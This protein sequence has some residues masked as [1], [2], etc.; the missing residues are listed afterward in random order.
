M[1]HVDL[2]SIIGLLALM[3]FAAK[4][5]GW[6]CKHAGQPAELGE[7]VAGVVLGASAN[8]PTNAK[9]ARDREIV[10]HGW[11]RSR[12]ANNSPPTTPNANGANWKMTMYASG[13]PNLSS[14]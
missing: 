5:A 6:V 10:L 1:P 4:S 13:G 7:L 14:S 8:P 12:N 11:C 3:L 2:P 9:T